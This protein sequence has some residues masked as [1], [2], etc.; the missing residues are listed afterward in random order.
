[1]LTKTKYN[2]LTIESYMLTKTN[3]VSWPYSYNTDLQFILY[4]DQKKQKKQGIVIV[5]I[6]RR[7]YKA[8][9]MNFS[10]LIIIIRII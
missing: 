5:H 9:W 4:V 1:M 3:L 10:T 8:V 6:N 7:I 2:K